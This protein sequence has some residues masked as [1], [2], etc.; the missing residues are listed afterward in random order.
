MNAAAERMFAQKFADENTGIRIGTAIIIA[1]SENRILMEKR[2]DCGLWGLPGGRVEPGESV[3]KA[4]QREVFEETGLSVRI[5]KLL[6]VYSD[7]AT[8]ILTYPEGDVKH[9]IDVVVTASIISGE[10]TKSAESEELR[11]FSG[12][13]LPEGI[14]PPA[15][16]PIK[17]Y[18]ENRSGIVE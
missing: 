8:H 4:A 7:P 3:S 9:I 17:D 12:E 2:A 16:A 6:G 14:M 15:L 1:D 5:G 18:F 13:N 11:F 10:L